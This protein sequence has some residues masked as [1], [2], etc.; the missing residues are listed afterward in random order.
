M[1]R[2][3]SIASYLFEQENQVSNMKDFLS[4]LKDIRK[5]RI[6]IELFSTQIK[7]SPRVIFVPSSG[8]L[9]PSNNILYKICQSKAF[10]GAIKPNHCFKRSHCHFGGKGCGQKVSCYTSFGRSLSSITD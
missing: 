10:F 7:Y 5:Y 9:V 2:N 1:E 3:H 4:K 6:G 8:I